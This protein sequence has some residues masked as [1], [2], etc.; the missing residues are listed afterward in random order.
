MRSKRF[1]SLALAACVAA[2]SAGCVTF[3]D[4]YDNKKAENNSSAE[5]K[6]DTEKEET[7]PEGKPG[8]VTLHHAGDDDESKA[9]KKETEG[10]T[11][12]EKETRPVEDENES[13]GEKYRRL[14]K[15][16]SDEAREYLMLK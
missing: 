15:M 2:L 10:S 3:V 8:R 14:L 7:A 12:E 13:L 4:S 16:S 6:K 1:L 9:D 11:K 5:I